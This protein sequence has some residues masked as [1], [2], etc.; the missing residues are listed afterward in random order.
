MNI[1]LKLVSVILLCITFTSKAEMIPIYSLNTIEGAELECSNDSVNLYLYGET[2]KGS[3]LVRKKSDM[4]EVISNTEYYNAPFYADDIESKSVFIVNKNYFIKDKNVI[5]AISLD[6][7]YYKDS[8]EELLI[9]STALDEVHEN[10]QCMS[11]SF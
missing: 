2:Y 7:F 10:G 4:F 11:W 9:I 6:P 1:I 8:N 5:S 3:I